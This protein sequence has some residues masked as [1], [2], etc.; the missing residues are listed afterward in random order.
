MLG[1]STPAHTKEQLA[2]LKADDKKTFEFEGKEYTKYEASQMMNKIESRVKKLKDRANIAAAAGDD[3]LRRE[4][5]YK[6][7]LLTNKYAQLSKASGLPT[8]M[9]RMQVA[10]FRSVK[11]RSIDNVGKDGIIKESDYVKMYDKSGKYLKSIPRPNVTLPDDTIGV[12]TQGTN[13]TDVEVFAGK[14]AKS[15]LRVREHLKNNYGGIADNWQHSKGH[16]FV[17]TPMGSKRAN[18]HWFE[19]ESVG[20]VEMYVKGWSKK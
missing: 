17:D 10:G 18:V 6:I 20:V 12:I 8:K 7:N 5:Q 15:E 19:E 16:A 11:I 4:E 9:E 13:I 2:Q 3:D 14:G 1:V